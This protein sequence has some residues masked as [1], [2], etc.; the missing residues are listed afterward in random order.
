MPSKLEI[1]AAI[2]ELEWKKKY[3]GVILHENRIYTLLQPHAPTDGKTK[4]DQLRYL[5]MPNFLADDVFPFENLLSHLFEI[6]VGEFLRQKYNY[7]N[8]LTRYNPIYLGGKEIDI[9]AEKGYRERS[10]TIC[11]CKLRLYDSPISLPEVEDFGEKVP[12][13]RE[14]EASIRQ[15]RFKFW[16]VTNADSLGVGVKA[17]AKRKKIELMKARLPTNWRNMSDWSVSSLVSF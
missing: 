8:V 12:V 2:D 3:I 1:D 5:Q 15:T 6:K 16:F 9:F 14:K 13:I 4:D 11:E 10:L 7:N 17:Y